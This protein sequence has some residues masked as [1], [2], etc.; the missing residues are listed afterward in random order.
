ML[1]T[2][3]S[4]T[5]AVFLALASGC[6]E[7]PSN[8]PRLIPV[9]GERGLLTYR[10]ESPDPGPEPATSSGYVWRPPLRSDA[11]DRQRRQDERYDRDMAE[12]RRNQYGQD[13]RAASAQ[14]EANRNLRRELA[15]QER[16]GWLNY[17]AQEA[18]RRQE[19]ERAAQERARADGLRQ[20]QEARDWL[21]YERD[22]QQ[23]T[24]DWLRSQQARY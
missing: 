6:D 3:R 18:N 8:E 2:R 21:R 23:Q 10:Y 11:E 9:Q 20:Q 15:S 4:A 13:L 12:W 7:S 24:R 17:Q 5:L 1:T 19:I 22:Q 14:E 16:Q